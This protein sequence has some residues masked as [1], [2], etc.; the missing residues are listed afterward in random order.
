MFIEGPGSGEPKRDDLQ[1][2]GPYADEAKNI[3]VENQVWSTGTGSV[4]FALWNETPDN[5]ATK[6]THN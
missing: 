5:P 1:S 2:A 6:A 3:H 4:D